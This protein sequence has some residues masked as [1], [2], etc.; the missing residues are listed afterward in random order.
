[1]SSA[2]TK[3]GCKV[4]LPVLLVLTIVGVVRAQQL[5]RAQTSSYQSGPHLNRIFST[6]APYGPLGQD[7]TIASEDQLLLFWSEPPPNATTNSYDAY[8]FQILNY[9][10]G[11]PSVPPDQL[12]YQD[13]ALTGD[14]VTDAANGSTHPAIGG[15]KNSIVVAGDMNGSGYDQAAAVWETYDPSGGTSAAKVFATV[16]PVNS[17]TLTFQN[18]KI[19]GEVVG[20]VTSNSSSTYDGLIQARM[21][22]LMGNGRKELIIAWHDP[23]DNNIH[24]AVYGWSA[25]SA[26]HLTLL[27][28]LSSA[29]PVS[30]SFSYYSLFG[31]ATGDF[32][33]HGV[34]QIALSG[35]NSNGSLYIKLFNFDSQDNIV[36]EGVA[37]VN[38]V[39]SGTI[40]RLVMSTGDLTGDSYRDDIALLL[41]YSGQ[42]GSGPNTTLYLAQTDT[43]LQNISVSSDSSISTDN[44]QNSGS[45]MAC[46]MAC[47]DLLGSRMDEVVTDVGNEVAVFEASQNGSY[48]LPVL[49]STAYVTGASDGEDYLYSDSYLKVGA[50]DQ[51]SK[52]DIVV[53]RNEFSL[54]SSSAYQAL[55]VAVFGAT[56]TNF[57][58]TQLAN[59]NSYMSENVSSSNGTN[60]LRRHYS[61]ALGDFDGGSLKLGTPTYFQVDSII[62]PLV[63]LNAPPVQFDVFNDTSFDICSVFNGGRNA[64]AFSAS[65]SQSTTNTNMMETSVTS[66]WGVG[67]SLSGSASYLGSKVEASLD[68]HYGQNFSDVQNSKYTNT[69]S[70][71]VS[72]QQEDEIYAIIDNYDLWEYPVLDSGK[73]RGH[74]L[75]TVPS[76]PEGEW[77]DTESWTAYSFIPDHVVGNVLSYLTYDS[78]ANN[79]YMMKK[80]KGSLSD[81]FELGTGK[82][83]W[84]L[85]T[86]DFQSNNVSQSETF[87]LN[88]S[89][90]ATVGGSFGGFGA[91]VTAGVSG[92]YSNSNLTSHTSSVTSTLGLTV[93]L[94]SINQSI[95]EDQYIV[96][97]Y[98]YWGNNGALVIDYA[99]QPVVSA[100][101][102]TPT[103]WQQMYGQAP[104]PALAL[105]YR[106][107]PQEGF[108]VQDPEKVY[109]TKEI[110]STPAAPAPGDTITT[111][112]RVHN[113][114]LIPTDT[115][116]QVSFFLG[117]P[118]NGG[119]IIKSVTGDSVF[120][121]P[122]YIPARGSQILSFKWIA[123][124]EVRSSF[125]H[126]Y[127]YVHLW[128]DVDPQNTMTEIHKDNNLGWSILQIPGIVTGV[129]GQ[130][131]Q[132]VAFSLNQNYPNPFNPTTVISY[133]IP[134]AG[135]VTLKVYDVL[136][137]EV[138]TLVNGNENIGA[139]HVEFNGSRLASG[140]YFYRL[141]SGSHIVTRKMMMLK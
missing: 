63:I 37:N 109:Q 86:S 117:N 80:I 103:W 46:S 128:A 12:L 75:V 38:T 92:D 132:P 36:P 134:K 102:G 81:G 112:V 44:F 40:S 90:K 14:S 127:D 33:H 13:G 69:V 22:D 45:L 101:G 68:T 113:Y 21:A 82:F 83:T 64:G 24:I 32:N 1:M 107:W 42:N 99:V 55:D 120:S 97:P 50:V 72:A 124:S 70:V 56:D 126:N 131:H 130:S 125:I 104:D 67:A 84:S 122:D 4:S 73:V 71:D 61:L 25:S 59:K 98:S 65:Y 26:S 76:P 2:I 62:Q 51:T 100:P 119:T 87:N 7:R 93:N 10:T 121:T 116:V 11:Q 30:T 16:L 20:Y 58:L 19:T 106:Y 9:L 141:I 114:S 91:S 123:P 48:L 85:T 139:Y 137:R 78:L 94:G 74:V 88:V 140:V 77:F 60:G 111:T 3:M 23:T 31:L 135:Y 43:S 133:T 52:S 39:Y 115:T 18:S 110:F 8:H 5:R 66:S 34:D 108:A 138:A 27:S 105:P 47:G 29:M 79:P 17:S 41:S 136:G 118:Q 15:N 49:K 28:S 6:S 95:G 57:T 129:L 53:L 35:F 54:G 89:A 96:T